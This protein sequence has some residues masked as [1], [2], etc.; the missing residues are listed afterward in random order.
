MLKR[1]QAI[2]IS[3]FFLL[4]LV[5]ATASFAGEATSG[6]TSQVLAFMSTHIKPYENALSGFKKVCDCDVR[7]IVF[8]ETGPY[9]DLS[10]EIEATRPDMVLAIGTKALTQLMNK[11]KNKHQSIRNIPIVYMMDLNPEP[12]TSGQKNITGVR[13]ITSPSKQLT[14]FLRAIPLIQRVGIVYNPAK[15]EKFVEGA[16]AAAKKVGVELLIKKAQKPEDVPGLVNEMAGEIDAFWMIPDASVVMSES[17]EAILLFSLENMVPVLTFSEKH[18]EI[19]ALMSMSVSINAADM[20]RQAGK[21]AERILHDG[22]DIAFIKAAY[23]EN[24]TLMVNQ[25]VAQSL[26]IDIAYDLPE[27]K[28]GINRVKESE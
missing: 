5:G 13:M 18:L 22:T 24:G 25:L 8:S 9:F 21:M 1:I 17:V 10:K 26:N 15:S 14:A 16:V 2:L 3:T 6:K 4:M 19:G 12:L 27:Y 7:K 23:A 28:P 11:L 20:G